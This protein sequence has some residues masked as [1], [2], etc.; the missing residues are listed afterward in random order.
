M[1][2]I[3]WNI[4][5]FEDLR[6]RAET[7]ALVDRYAQQVARKA[8]HGYGFDGQQGASRYHA[9]VYPQSKRAKFTEARTNKLLKALE[10]G[11]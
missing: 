9:I 7:T 5:G 2:R 8:G 1:T 3:E 4:K 11:V 6:R 10:G